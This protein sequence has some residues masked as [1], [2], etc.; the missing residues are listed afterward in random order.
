[1]AT[2]K[3]RPRQT[4]S[5]HD[6]SVNLMNNALQYFKRINSKVFLRG[7]TLLL[8]H[9]SALETFGLQHGIPAD[10]IDILVRQALSGNLAESVSIR[11]LKCLLPATGVLQDSV[12]AAV[13]LFC[14]GK[15]S[16]STRIFFIRWLTSVYDLIQCKDILSSLYNFFFCFIQDDK[17]CPSLCHLLYLVTRME[18]VRA[19]RVRI[20]LELQSRKG[21]QPHI[22]GL[23]SLYKVFCPELVSLTLPGKIKVYF[24]TSSLLFT[25]E[26]KAIAKRNAGDPVGDNK[27][28]LCTPSRKRKWNSNTVV[29]ICSSFSWDQ[30]SS[31]AYRDYLSK[32]PTLPVEKIQTLSQLLENIMTF[33]LPAQM[34]CILNNSVLPHYVSCAR[35]DDSLL[36]L[37]FW[38]A[39]TMHE[40]CAWYTGKKHIKEEVE[41][42]LSNVMNMQEFLQEGLSGSEDFLYKCL[43][44][45]NGNYR[46]QILSLLSWISPFSCTEFENIFFETLVQ[47]FASS[48]LYFKLDVLKMLKKLLQNWLI[49]HSVSVELGIANNDDT[50]GLMTSVDN[51]I[52]FTT[53][54]GILGLDM[55]DSPLILHFI[56]DFYALVCDIYVRF[57]LPLIVLPPARVFYTALLC[58]DAV[59]LNQLCYI[60]YR[61]REN[62]LTAKRTERQNT[63]NVPFPVSKQTFE[64]Y[65]Q[66]LSTMVGCLWTSQALQYDT[67]PQGIKLAPEVLENAGVPLNK[68][69][70]NIVFHPALMGFAAFFIR[71]RFPQENMFQLNVLQ[72]KYWDEYIDSLY[73]KGLCG[74]KLFIESSVNRVSS[75][76]K[77]EDEL[78]SQSS[79][80]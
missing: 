4:L 66:Y 51:I 42:F 38:L 23:L 67:H 31:S 52:Q 64:E 63:G 28:G 49:R 26:L 34:G 45:W 60:M 19:Y 68:K 5:R 12:I 9:L 54:L 13:S 39:F 56:L 65:N 30:K 29:P 61:Y 71:E 21:L 11:I 2:P 7:N 44:H 74:L 58:T 80:V 14:T 25:S 43:P 41:S 6:I 79:H 15:S 59:N 32:N 10:G 3:L 27:L 1:M 53:Q 55:H 75:K 62:L 50:S 73:N 33:E 72:G 24:K 17:L 18:H 37:N 8:Q 40:E 57:S 36:R 48:S 22:L 70:F 46:S 77:Q 47:L 78:P 76:K 20:L 69:R 16:S 35:E